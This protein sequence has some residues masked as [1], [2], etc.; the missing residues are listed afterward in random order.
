MVKEKV[1]KV[2]I[3][4]DKVKGRL[5]DRKSELE[6]ELADLAAEK[7]V[8]DQVLDQGDL[9]LSSSI[10]ALK[11][12]MQDNEFDEY[13]RIIRALEMIDEGTYGICMDCGEKILD[14]RL[15]SSPNAARCIICQEAHEEKSGF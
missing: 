5:L 7:V 15:K 4:F 6:G 10:E 14:K 2:S 3:D 13:S 8:T 9:A 11:S 1:V 12:S